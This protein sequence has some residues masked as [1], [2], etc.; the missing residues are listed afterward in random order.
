MKIVIQIDTDKILFFKIYILSSFKLK[1]PYKSRKTKSLTLVFSPSSFLT[2][3][4]KLKG[5]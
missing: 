3:L 4:A 2:F 1:N 5:C